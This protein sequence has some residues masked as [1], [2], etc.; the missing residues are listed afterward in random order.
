MDRNIFSWKWGTLFVNSLS[1]AEEAIISSAKKTN[2]RAPVQQGLGKRKR[3]CPWPKSAPHLSGKFK[4]LWWTGGWHV[5]T[6]QSKIPNCIDLGSFY[7]VTSLLEFRIWR[8]VCI[9]VCHPPVI[10]L[11]SRTP[12]SPL[13]RL[14]LQLFSCP[15][16]WRGL[17]F[18][19]SEKSGWP[20]ILYWGNV[21]KLMPQ[22]ALKSVYFCD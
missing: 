1:K 4:L 8:N 17:S 14:W 15:F 9:W 19:T 16:T 7:W 3:K 21:Q 13:T 12:S 6:L 10:S 22:H 11:I 5:A 20:Q 2:P 18:W